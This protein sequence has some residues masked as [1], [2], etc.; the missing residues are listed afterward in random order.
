M[1]IKL[2]YLFQYLDFEKIAQVISSSTTS[3]LSSKSSSSNTMSKSFGNNTNPFRNN[4]TISSSGMRPPRIDSQP[5]HNIPESNDINMPKGTGSM[6]RFKNTQ[7]TLSHLKDNHLLSIPKTFK[8][9]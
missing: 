8:F 4:Q 1:N 6:S 9:R 2:G 7:S 5:L 3:S